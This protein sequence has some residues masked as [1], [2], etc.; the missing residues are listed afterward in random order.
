MNSVILIIGIYLSSVANSCVPE[1]HAI[2]IY[3]SSVANSCVPEQQVTSIYL[4][5]VANICLPKQ[6]GNRYPPEQCVKQLCT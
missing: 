2:G 6:C 4:S 1:Q 5:S 3:L